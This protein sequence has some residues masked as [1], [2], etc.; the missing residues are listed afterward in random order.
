MGVITDG[1]PYRL[2]P[3][4]HQTEDDPA[5]L[6]DPP[7]WGYSLANVSE[8][9]VGC[10][11][12]AEV[13]SIL[14]IGA[15]QGELTADLL[16]WA[17][18]SG[19]TIATIDPVPPDKL[20]EL[21]EA[22]PE[23]ELLQE[24]SHETLRKLEALPHSIVI[25]GDHN[26]YTLSEELRLIGE[27]AGDGHIPL[28]FFHDV[29]WPHARRDTYY[30]PE[31]IPEDKHPPIGAN[32]GLAPGEPGVHPLGLPYPWAALNE[33]GPANGTVT[34]IEDFMEGSPGLRFALV[35]AFFGLGVLWDE[36]A[37]WAAEVAAVLAPFDRNP[38]L[39][40]LEEN[41][42]E[43]MVAG[44]ARAVKLGRAEE[45]RARQE[46]VIRKI[47][48]SRAFAIAERLSSLA[49]RGGPPLISRAELRGTLNSPD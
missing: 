1:S 22:H 13:R 25:D 43:H 4:H 14:E 28:L 3:V 49:Q 12:A 30:A 40:R 31:R 38:I 44:H 9:I 19:A 23:L 16:D 17:S 24:T 8:I 7:P 36:G 11:D 41:R 47:L 5:R 35:P 33:G 32:V 46:V 20:L 34:A 18:S 21:A 37:P 26:Y 27:R 10:L 48:A 42:V 45:Q 2:A 39:T 29:C 15:F 6:S